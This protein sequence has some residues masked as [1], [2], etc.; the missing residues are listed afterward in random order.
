VSL[1]VP[2]ATRGVPLLISAQFVSGL[3]DSALLLVAI[4]EIQA[5]DGP[6]WLPPLL[7]LVFTLAYVVLAPFVGV[8]A[9]RWPKAR[10]MSRANAVKAGACA[11]MALG[12]PVGPCFCIAGA[13]AALYSPAKYGLMTELVPPHRLVAANG[14]IEVATVVAILLGT[15]L[16]GT[17]VALLAPLAAFAVLLAL[18]GLAA[19]LNLGIPDSGARYPAP[20]PLR[21]QLDDF[22][23]DNMR[24]WR[25]PLGRLS[26][27]TTTL[28]WGV[29]A[30]L[31]FLVLRWAVERLGLTLAQAAW[32]QG[33]SATGVVLGAALAGRF[34]ALDRAVGVRW[35]GV[36]LGLLLLLPIPHVHHWLPAVPLL[37]AAGAVAG[38]FVVPMNALLQH[39]GA[40]L[41]SAGRSIA[42]QNFNEN[43]SVL[44]MLAAYAACTAHDV[45]LDTL[46]R[47]FGLLVAL[48]T[49]LIVVTRRQP[50][51][52]PL[53]PTR[54]TTPEDTP[55]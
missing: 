39:R 15:L 13:G 53:P 42:V 7:K 4:A 54:G 3:A 49:T 21:H 50:A 14:W 19:L 55:A 26:L 27:A 20:P 48:L 51:C 36:P 10:V 31:Q 11:A 34:V 5:H 23:A 2:A 35:L 44:L 8:L 16:G 45:P 30:T 24:L 1:A 22:L 18:Y 33:L 52:H 25:D 43:A 28:F 47:G 29:G 6:A 37:A 46:I 17:L 38:L 9:D 41:L 12:V 40:T 32:L